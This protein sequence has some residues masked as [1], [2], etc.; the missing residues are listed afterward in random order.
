MIETF[1]KARVEFL[2][3]IQVYGQVSPRKSFNKHYCEINSH[4]KFDEIYLSDNYQSP[5]KNKI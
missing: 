1:D 4:N 5:V 2:N 3:D